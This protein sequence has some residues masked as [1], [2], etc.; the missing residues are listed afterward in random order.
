[1]YKITHTPPNVPFDG[2]TC[3]RYDSAYLLNKVVFTV[4]DKCLSIVLCSARAPK[5]HRVCF[6]IPN[7]SDHMAV[8]VIADLDK[9]CLHSNC[10]T[11]DKNATGK[12]GRHVEDGIFEI[13]QY[14]CLSLGY[15]RLCHTCGHK[16]RKEVKK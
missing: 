7:F 16:L 5:K 4:H 14:F 13:W 3:T 12:W 11:P 8:T 2:I 1:M 6:S 9:Y 10:S 15:L